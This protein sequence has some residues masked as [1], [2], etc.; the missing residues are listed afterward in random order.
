[1]RTPWPD[2]PRTPAA[3]PTTGRP[4]DAL[5]RPRLASTTRV[6]FLLA[7]LGAPSCRS[8]GPAATPT[9]TPQAAVAEAP[10]RPAVHDHT[11]RHG[12]VVGMSGQ[13]HV[14][15]VARAN[16]TIRVWVTD[17]WR[18][19]MP[20][21]DMAGTVTIDLGGEKRRL[22]LAAESDGLVA[23][24][25]KLAG[26]DVDARFEIA[27]GDEPI[28]IEFRLPV[29]GRTL[30]AGGI[31][32]EGCQPLDPHILRGA[33][34]LPRCVLPFRRDVV[35]IAA[36][37]AGDRML[38]AGMD[39]G[40]SEWQLPEASLLFGLA[41]PAAESGTSGDESVPHREAD[42]IA[43]RPDGAEAALAYGDRVLRRSMSDGA[44]VGAW[45]LPAGPVRALAWSPD[46]KRL[47]AIVRGDP[48]ARVLRTDG[49]AAATGFEVDREAWAVAFSP[50][51]ATLAVGSAAGGTTLFDTASGSRSISVDPAGRPVTAVAFLDRTRLVTA[52]REGIVATWDATSGRRLAESP[53][54]RGFQSLAIDAVR[55]RIAI[56]GLEGDLRIVDVDGRPVERLLWHGAE[57]TGLAFAGDLLVSG[58]TSGR[59]AIWDL[60]QPAPAPLPSPTPRTAR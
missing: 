28:L 15:A 52:S 59:V 53:H 7:L 30:G 41:P 33:R 4:S 23:E 51:G 22:E 20:L 54:G 8:G 44:P 25:P 13:R 49:G 48:T 27:L 11:P 37:R 40:G 18:T 3:V 34:R 5:P 2:P 32:V 24:G 58:D 42:A 45:R 56:G 26:D 9:P 31:P 29:S 6:A 35:A 46:G 43:I 39:A 1:M 57:V 17:F 21:D 55:G 50:D 16:G 60:A 38:I 14:E 36:T 19:P 47:A 12:G 10:A